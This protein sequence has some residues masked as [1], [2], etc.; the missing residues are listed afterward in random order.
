MKATN[1]SE[2]QYNVWN[3]GSN[4]SNLSDAALV[5]LDELAASLPDDLPIGDE[6]VYR[7]ESQFADDKLARIWSYS[8]LCGS[9]KPGVSEEH[10]FIL[11]LI[12]KIVGYGAGLY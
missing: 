6:S 9:P 4:A 10:G 2:L 5:F 12:A 1:F 7:H 3:V 11:D 8:P